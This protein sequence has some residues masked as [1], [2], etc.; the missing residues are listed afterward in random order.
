MYQIYK[1]TYTSYSKEAVGL[2]PGCLF[3]TWVKK[4]GEFGFTSSHLIK[5]PTLV[6]GIFAIQSKESMCFPCTRDQSKSEQEKMSFSLG[7]CT[8]KAI[9]DSHFTFSTVFK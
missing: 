4:H 1:K 2:E 9:I 6:E 7:F 5:S 8:G 3:C